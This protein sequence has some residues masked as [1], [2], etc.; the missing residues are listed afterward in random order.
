MRIIELENGMEIDESVTFAEGG[1]VLPAGIRVRGDGLTIDGNGALLVGEKQ[2]GIGILLEDCVDVTIKNVGLTQFKHGIVARNCNNLRIEG[3]QIAGTA[4]LPANSVF[5]NIW[6]PVEQAY[7]GGILLEHV[8]DTVI[9]HNELGHQMSGLLTYHCR[10]LTVR[11][12]SANYC[13]FAGFHLHDT[14]DSIYE[15]NHADFCCRYHARGG[16]RGHMGADSAGFVIVVDSCRNSFRHNK[17]RMGGDGFFLAGL[18][19]K[20]VHRPCNENIFEGNDGSYSPNIAF[21]ATFSAGNIYRHNIARACNYG[22]WLGFSRNS[23]LTYNVITECRQAGIAT[24]NGIH[25]HVA[26]N[27]FTNNR[28]AILLWSKHMPNLLKMVPDN[29]TSAY[30]RIENNRFER[31]GKAIRIAANQDHGIVPYEPVAPQLP[32]NHQ[33]AGNQM[34]D[35][36]QDI[37]LIEAT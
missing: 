32:H 22:F 21:E 3:C 27:R 1:W 19:N 29:V 8:T 14:S 24:E 26:N 9:Q 31:N 4:E 17:A 7:G 37:E 2:T 11:E 35:N 15:K 25:F 16:N 33:I 12:N 28:H 10:H 34:F 18:T 13:S 36:H 30:W 6:L 5:L 20:L 23:E